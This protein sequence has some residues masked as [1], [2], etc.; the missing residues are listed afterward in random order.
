MTCAKNEYSTTGVENGESDN[1]VIPPN[2]LPAPV[3]E[4]SNVTPDPLITA[5]NTDVPSWIK[6]TV[7][8]TVFT[9]SG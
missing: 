7:A 2:G 6:E 5:E 3:R 8:S 4:F 1:A 9:L